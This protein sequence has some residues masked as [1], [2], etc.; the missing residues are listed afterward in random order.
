MVGVT[1]NHEDSIHVS[2]TMAPIKRVGYREQRIFSLRVALSR[3]LPPQPSPTTLQAYMVECLHAE[4]SVVSEL[5][6]LYMAA[7]V[8]LG[9]RQNSMSQLK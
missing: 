1:L 3:N 6:A 2:S 8:L 9:T 7:N 5:K 4:L